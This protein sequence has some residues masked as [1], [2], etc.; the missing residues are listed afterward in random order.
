MSRSRLGDHFLIP[1]VRDREC[2]WASVSAGL[3]ITGAANMTIA[4]IVI[5][6]AAHDP[7]HYRKSLPPENV[8]I[9]EAMVDVMPDEGLV[10]VVAP[11]L[12]P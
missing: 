1:T 5:Q 12:C 6:D 7:V 8:A 4:S 11:T 9:A 10:E 2:G 3:V